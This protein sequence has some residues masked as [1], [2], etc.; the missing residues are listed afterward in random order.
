MST[1]ADQFSVLFRGRNDA[2]GTDEGGSVRAAP[3]WEAHLDG[4][5][6]MGIYPLVYD[7]LDQQWVVWWTCID[8]DVKRPGKNRWDYETEDDAAVAAQNLALTLQQFGLTPWV[9][10]TR[11]RGR[12]VW[13]F[14][15]GPCDATLARNAMLAACMVAEVPPTEVN[16]KSYGFDDE[17]TLGNY[18]RLPYPGGHHDNRYMVDSVGVPFACEDF[19]WRARARRSWPSH[20]VDLA[21][22]Y[23]PP[24]SRVVLTGD[25]EYDGS[26]NGDITPYVRA[27]LTNGPQRGEDR[28]GWLWWLGS[29]CVDEG[30]SP[31][32]ALQVLVTADTGW[33]HK[34]VDRHDGE[35][36]LAAI[37]EKVYK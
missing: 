18:V 5:R 10:V 7:K 19:V 22:L 13:A 4:R 17:Y 29:K 32:C 15:N 34:Y 1:L 6:P 27:V 12:H 11:S 14:F 8:L 35:K 9:E 31:E 23:V 33:T 36:Y 24:P 28:S 21:A 2:Y 16:P 20:L 3:D 37:V 25:G 30:L 26:L